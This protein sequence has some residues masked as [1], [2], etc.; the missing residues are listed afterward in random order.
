MNEGAKYGNGDWGG[1]GVTMRTGTEM[2]SRGRTQ[3]GNGDESGG[4]NESISGDG[5]GYEDGI[6]DGNGDGNGDRIGEGEEVAKKRKKP[7]NNC[8]RDQRLYPARV[9]ISA[10][11]G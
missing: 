4:G 11:R 8:R 6:R 3:D 7:H 10:D 5:N 2:E 9:I 1:D